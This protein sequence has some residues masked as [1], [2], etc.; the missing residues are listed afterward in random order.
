MTS[1]T[2]HVP[3]DNRVLVLWES[4]SAQSIDAS[5]FLAGAAGNDVN[6]DTT[7]DPTTGASPA[8]TAKFWQVSP[9]LPANPG[10]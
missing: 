5:R 9:T 2:Y 3:N 4:G 6:A 7:T 8:D 1:T 10:P